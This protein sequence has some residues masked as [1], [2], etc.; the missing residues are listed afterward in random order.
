MTSYT[1]EI[2]AGKAS[3]PIAPT[4]TIASKATAAEVAK[5]VA[6]TRHLGESL[7]G[8]RVCVWVGADADTE[9]PADAIYRAEDL[10]REDAAA[11]LRAAVDELRDA[12]ARLTAAMLAA[13]VASVG[14]NEIARI[15][16]PVV[17]RATVLKRLEAGAA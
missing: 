12:R 17:S 2:Q 1:V 16:D 14:R 10:T 7:R 15:A 9:L 8:W 3:Q 6:R 5:K 4:E 11:D 13:D